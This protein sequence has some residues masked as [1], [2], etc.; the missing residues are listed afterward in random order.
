MPRLLGAMGYRAGSSQVVGGRGEE[1]LQG[2]E[3]GG[4]AAGLK[5]ATAS[6]ASQEGVW[7]PGC[8]CHC[9]SGMEQGYLHSTVPLR[10]NGRFQWLFLV[11]ALREMIW[12]SFDKSHKLS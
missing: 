12:L 3:E 2:G 4:Y 7:E 6:R 8:V 9:S 10:L 1:T 11:T 5:H